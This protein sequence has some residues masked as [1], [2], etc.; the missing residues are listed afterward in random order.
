M[1]ADVFTAH[2]QHAVDR[3]DLA[4]GGEVVGGQ[5]TDAVRVVGHDRRAVIAVDV[6][7]GV[8]L[9]QGA[10]LLHALQHLLAVLEGRQLVHVAHDRLDLL[11]AHH[12]A[13]GA[14]RGK[15]RRAR[16]GVAEGYAGQVALVLTNRTA[17][18]EADLLAVFLVQFRRRLESAL[19]EILGAGL[20]G[21]RPVLAQVD[22][23]PVLGRPVEREARDLE[24]SHR[25]PERAAG[26]RFL[27][28]A[29]QRALAAD[30]GAVRVR[31][32]AAGEGAGGENQ[33]IVRRQR[34][35][36]GSTQLVQRLGDEVA[37]GL[38]DLLAR[39]GLFAHGVPRDV[40]V[41]VFAHVV[42]ASRESGRRVS[43]GR[44][45]IKSPASYRENT[46]AN[47]AIVTF[48]PALPSTFRRAQASA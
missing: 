37:A 22:H 41:K 15:A 21:D 13:D 48:Q 2:L 9:Q 30:A 25:Q 7:R 42:C 20:E 6:D 12:G 17:D 18:G 32:V 36:L 16:I 34:L 45:G 47:G 14:A 27:D 24:V 38:R 19:A 23:D 3:I 1:L 10:V 26:V 28:A 31:P 8:G 44:A 33:R 43:G 29:G 40:D 5:A 11:A 35:D 4:P 46:V 39:E